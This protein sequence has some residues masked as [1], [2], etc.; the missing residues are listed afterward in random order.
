MSDAEREARALLAEAREALDTV[1]D[2]YIPVHFDSCLWLQA[3]RTDTRD[4]R[5]ESDL[6]DCAPQPLIRKIRA[7]EAKAS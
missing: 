5:T 3:V 2:W 1:G 7:F 4:G 6:C